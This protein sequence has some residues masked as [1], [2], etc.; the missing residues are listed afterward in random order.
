MWQVV[1]R[2]AAAALFIGLAANDAAA[3]GARV[4]WA[5]T[6]EVSRFVLFV[7]QQTDGDP[8]LQE[9]RIDNPKLTDEGNFFYDVG[10]L[11]P[12]LPTFF[13]MISVTWQNIY[14]APSNVLE[15]GSDSFCDTL[16]IDGD[17][18][19]TTVDAL[20]VARVA[21]GLEDEDDM[22]MPA[23]ITL[24]LEVLRLAAAFEC[25]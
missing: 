10:N 12:T 5:Q 11:D 18:R 1:S 6:G 3:A 21:V 8:K 23:S 22:D 2:V 20:F 17:G 19:V 7:A 15:L 25:R 4:E 14:S 16:D 13:V 24:A 9:L